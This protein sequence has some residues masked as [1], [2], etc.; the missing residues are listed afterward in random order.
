MMKP[1]EYLVTS[2]EMQRYDANTIGSF[3]IPGIVLMEQAAVAC[4]EEVVKIPI[5]NKNVLILAG[6]GNNGG[7]AM[8]LARL[9]HQNQYSVTVC[10]ISNS[11][12]ELKGFS[13]SAKIQYDILISMGIPIVTKLPEN[14]Y[15]MIID[16]VF[17]V[18]LSRDITGYVAD[19]INMINSYTGIKIAIDM[20]SGIDATSGKV[21]NV[22]FKADITITI[23]FLKRGLFLLPGAKYAGKVI[24]RTIGITE[25]SF[26]NNPPQM[27]SL[28]GSIF[29]YLPKRDY[30]GHKGT[31]GKILLICGNEEIGGAAIL[32]GRASFKSGS[33][34]VRIC[35]HK[36]QKSDIITAMP[37]AMV[38]AYSNERDAIEQLTKGIAWADVIAIGPGIGTSSIAKELL[39]YVI[40]NSVKPLVLD[41]DAINLLADSKI[42]NELKVLQSNDNTKRKLI[43]TPHP[44]ELAR[45]CGCN[46]KDILENGILFASNLANDL[47]AVV[48]KKD[49]NTLITDGKWMALNLCGNS[50]MAT[51]GSGDVLCGIM[52]S[53]MAL[54]LSSFDTAIISV[55]LHALAGDSMALDSNEYSLIASDIIEGI[56]K[57]LSAK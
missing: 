33:G 34:M 9:L 55:Y 14:T 26:L 45:I 12:E 8:A 10:I 22:A 23:A 46:I 17:G 6:K 39:S 16:G 31:F 13:E 53:L 36:N 57:V 24:K 38:D 52:A 50:G 15:D 37:E 7:D 11:P 25:D 43:F 41:A 54:G 18:G 5:S 1:I 49:A 21:Y 4:Y 28:T 20:P 29:D 42:Y 19:A 30:W 3:K 27:F 47:N 56:V 48:V 44:L 35:T 32:C 51:A 40:H 2:Q